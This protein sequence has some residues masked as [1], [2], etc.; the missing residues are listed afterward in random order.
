M[1]S[2]RPR[3][4]FR[5]PLGPSDCDGVSFGDRCDFVHCTVCLHKRLLKIGY[6]NQPRC[7]TPNSDTYW[8]SPVCSPCNNESRSQA[9]ESQAAESQAVES[10]S[11]E[12]QAPEAPG[13]PKFPSWTPDDK[14]KFINELWQ[15]QQQQFEASTSKQTPYEKA[16]LG[17]PSNIAQVLNRKTL[18]WVP[19]GTCKD[20]T[21]S[22]NTMSQCLLSLLY[23]SPEPTPEPTPPRPTTTKRTPPVVPLSERP[24]ESLNSQEIF[25]LLLEINL[26][27]RPAQ[28]ASPANNIIHSPAISRNH[29][30]PSISRNCSPSSLYSSASPR[31]SSSDDSSQY[32]TILKRPA[33]W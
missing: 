32:T 10:Q 7:P 5:Q 11:A 26:P 28:P 22:L 25:Q 9:S 6:Y 13:P 8:E 20:T 31:S 2:Q 30:P 12:S 14:K 15:R 21:S 24:F 3:S 4:A 16:L 27:R 18:I 19:V 17:R 1:A 23:P 29:S 33:C